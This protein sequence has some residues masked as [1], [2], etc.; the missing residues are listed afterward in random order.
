MLLTV[1]VPVYNVEPY[2]DR[3]VQSI[4]Q[5]TYR[6]LEIIL[7]D[8]G[9]TD[10]S[11]QMCEL[12]AQ[13]DERIKVIHKKNG[14]LS[15]ARNAGLDIAQGEII[16]FIDSDDFIEL[17]MYRIMITALRNSGKDIAC[18]GRIVDLWGKRE[19]KEFSISQPRIYTQEEAIKEVLCLRDIDVSACDKLYRK[20]LF[21]ELRYPIGK[22]SEDAAIIFQILEKTNGVIHVG[23]DFYH[24]IFRRNS[25]SKASYTH[26]KFD[27]YENCVFITQFFKKYHPYL[28][29]YVK[30]YNTQVCASLLES[31]YLDS[32]SI[33][34]YKQD[35]EVYRAM[36]KKGFF[37]AMV[38]KRIS[39]KIKIRLM[40]VWLGKTDCFNKLKKILNR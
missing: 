37:L 21:Y 22:T 7:V 4:V 11:P 23:K 8:D 32:Q 15:S 34:K 24:Y 5:Q 9:S 20:T 18:C 13:K 3:C 26:A 38:Q 39:P 6:K 35:F 12:W 36:F 10:N 29:S 19:K 2:L 14:G 30:I 28:M 25:I 27:A 17:D 40:F 16:S 33:K 31:M 1:I